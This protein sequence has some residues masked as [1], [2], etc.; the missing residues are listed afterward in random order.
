MIKIL[1]V[2][3]AAESCFSVRKALPESGIPG[4]TVD[5]K[6]SYREILDG[7]RGTDY[8]LCVIDSACGNGPRLFAQARSLGFIAPII[9]VTSDDAREA[10][11]AIRS[12][13]SDCLV[14]DDLTA[15]GI[16]RLFCSVVEQARA[17]AQ[18]N[19]RA[20][21]YL[22]LVDNAD[23]VIFT[24]DLNGN[25][26][27][28]NTTAAQLTGYLQEELLNL[29]VLKL[30]APA[31]CEAVRQMIRET[32]SMR[33]Q[34]SCEIEIVTKQGHTLFFEA[35]SHLVYHQGRAVEVQWIARSLGSS[36]QPTRAL[37]HGAQL[38]E[39]TSIKDSRNVSV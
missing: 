19:D 39:D 32:L 30:V 8:D 18:E 11:N 4:F 5:L 38:H 12:G 36:K 7:F 34:T 10:V 15:A 31:Y 20:R 37:F 21:R 1:V 2:D 22:A 9:L 35:N 28:M 17:T 14:R 33:R 26:T 23:E 25:C 27:S 24:H 13:V 29:P 16:E 6:F 3:Q